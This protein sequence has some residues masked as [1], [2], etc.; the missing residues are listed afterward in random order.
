MWASRALK[1]LMQAHELS[2]ALFLPE[3]IQLAGLLARQNALRGREI[4]SEDEGEDEHDWRRG[5]RRAGD[6]LEG[7]KK[8]AK[9]RV[10]YLKSLWLRAIR[11]VSLLVSESASCYIELT[12]FP[13]SSSARAY[14]TRVGSRTL[15]RWE[16]R[17][18]SRGNT[19][20]SAPFRMSP[21]SRAD[22]CPLQTHPQTS[23]SPESSAALLLWPPH[24][25]G[26][27]TFRCPCGNISRRFRPL[28][29]GSGRG[30]RGF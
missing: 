29:A 7:Q 4:G 24:P 14:P 10:D 25:G 21:A 23:I 5:Q 13:L 17:R 18:S 1:V 30:S 6:K 9:A 22:V 11:L 19:R 28:C 26:R 16:L 8:A 20:V 27:S 12:P 3:C 15:R 2:P